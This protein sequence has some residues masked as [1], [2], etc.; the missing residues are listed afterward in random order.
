MEAIRELTEARK[1]EL[2]EEAKRMGEIRLKVIREGLEGTYILTYPYADI[3]PH[4]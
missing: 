3:N 2:L 4:Q 1:Q